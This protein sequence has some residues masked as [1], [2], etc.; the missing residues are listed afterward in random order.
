MSCLLV[1][2]FL[3]LYK[4][5]RAA[6]N[7]HKPRA[8]LRLLK[9]YLNVNDAQFWL[10]R[11]KPLRCRWL[12]MRPLG[13]K[14]YPMLTGCIGFFPTWKF[15]WGRFPFNKNRRFKFSEFSL[16]K[17]S[18]SDR[19]LEFEVTCSVTHGMLSEILLCLK[20]AHFFI[21]FAASKQD[22]YCLLYTSPSPR[23][24]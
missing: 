2:F 3:M 23:D 12:V 21:I 13:K 22:I 14:M 19:L 24:A 9:S 10:S 6:T 4:L 11:K 16:V 18:E 7:R 1:L 8:F 15:I 5:V 17:W 20:T